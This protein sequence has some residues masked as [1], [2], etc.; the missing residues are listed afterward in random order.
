MK[1]ILT[2][3]T[4]GFCMGVRRAVEMA[5]QA[6]GSAPPPVYSWGPLIHNRRVTDLLHQQGIN[7]TNS[8]PETGTVVIRAHGV[9]P[10]VL[11]DL[12]EKGIHVVDATCPHV[13]ASQQNIR[14]HSAKGLHTVIAGDP[15][16][17][18]V[19]GLAGYSSTPV[20]ILS[21]T[22]EA[23]TFQPERA[24][25][26]IAQTTFL[27]SLY[28]QM[29]DILQRRFAECR[30][31]ESI[32]NATCHRQNEARKLAEAVGALIVAGDPESANTRRL[33]EVGREAG[34]LVWLVESARE[35]HAEDLS[36]LPAIGL[37][38]G[39]STPDWVID[40]IRQYLAALT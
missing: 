21:T 9:T 19:I 29:T 22:E 20:T 8:V 5:L 27:G 40:E 10:S 24:F 35:L 18:E 30:V 23:E 7:V 39:A 32:C 14:T 12:Q 2:A 38:A 37:T 4:A 17:P 15:A 31:V 13:I 33:A 3:R 11:N 28:R 26:V 16:H 36:P 6:A 25:F 1:Q 34:A